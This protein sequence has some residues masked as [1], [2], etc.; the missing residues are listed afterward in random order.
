MNTSMKSHDCSSK[1]SAN[2]K[3]N[4]C[5]GKAR[6]GMVLHGSADQVITSSSNGKV[7]RI[8]Q[9]QG[10]ADRRREAGIFLAE[11][12]KLFR[13][14]PEESI[15]E[16]YLSEDT[17]ERVAEDAVLQ[18]K[19]HRTGYETVS[20]EVF[21]KMSDTKTPQGILCVIRRPE[22]KLEQL[23][24]MPSPLLVV[25]ESLQ[26]P[27]NLGTILRAGEAAGVTGVIM[28]GEMADIFHPKTIRATMGSVFRVPF[29]QVESLK[30]AL[31]IL[32]RKNIRIYAGH[33]SGKICYDSFSFKGGTA[34]LIGNEG[35]GLTWETARM[36]DDLLKIPMEG[37][38][39]SLNASV[40]AALLMYEAYRQRRLPN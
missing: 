12:F 3:P 7:K 37:Q 26:D 4:G 18:E 24:N 5:P 39:E 29:V 19:L 31:E 16:V 25:L 13:E 38:V 35:N 11:G 2:M 22:Y 36:A 23:V 9:W 6:N 33:L 21:C 1:M 27:G 30:E 17:L 34:F 40:A 10:K 14:A 20:R 8:V 15:Q 32:K 28:G